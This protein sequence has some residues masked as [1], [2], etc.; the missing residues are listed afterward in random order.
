[1]K[2]TINVLVMEDNKYYNGLLSSALKQSI[3]KIR[4]KFNSRVVLHSFTDSQRCMRKIKAN[5]LINNDTIAFVDYYLGDG[6]NGSHIIK[7]LKEQSS[8]VMVILLSQSRAVGQRSNQARYDYFVIKDS[9]ALA[10]CC[11]YLEQFA[12]NKFM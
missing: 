7:M 2:K 1:M 10:L 9:S 8:D 11:L 4:E 5:E 12:D 6:V 3:S